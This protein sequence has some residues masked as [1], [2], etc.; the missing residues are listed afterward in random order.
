MGIEKIENYTKTQRVSLRNKGLTKISELEVFMNEL[1]GG[2]LIAFPMQLPQH[3]ILQQILIEN[4]P[5]ETADINYSKE[6]R[7]AKTAQLWFASKKL[8]RSDELSKYIGKN[9][10]TKIIVKITKEKG[11]MPLRE[12]PVDEETRKKMMS[13]WHKKQEQDKE[14]KEDDD[15][16][17]LQSDWADTSSLKQSFIGID[18]NLQFK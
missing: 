3:D 5:L 18:K 6:I 14:L 7:D 12:P 4:I 8:L 1:R 2:L 16:S 11:H 13:Y 17:Y 9:E 10:K 15:T